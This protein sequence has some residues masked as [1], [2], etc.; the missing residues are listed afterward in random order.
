MKIVKSHKR[1]VIAGRT[2]RGKQFGIKAAR[3]DR[4]KIRK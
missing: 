1:S 4:I 2:S 3:S